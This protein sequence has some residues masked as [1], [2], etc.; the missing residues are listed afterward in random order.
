MK[1]RLEKESSRPGLKND[2]IFNAN[3]QSAFLH[4]ALS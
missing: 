2:D 3:G 4:F 1:E